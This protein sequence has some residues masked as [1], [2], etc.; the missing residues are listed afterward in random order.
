MNITLFIHRLKREQQWLTT[1]TLVLVCSNSAPPYPETCWRYRCSTILLPSLFLFSCKPNTCPTKTKLF[2]THVAGIVVLLRRLGTRSWIRTFLIIL[3]IMYCEHSFSLEQWQNST[4][5]SCILITWMCSGDIVLCCCSVHAAI[6]Y[7]SKWHKKPSLS[8][9]WT[10]PLHVSHVTFWVILFS[11]N[12][13]YSRYLR[14]RSHSFRHIHLCRIIDWGNERRQ[15]SEYIR[16][17]FHDIPLDDLN[18]SNSN[19]R[20]HS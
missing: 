20:R 6:P 11:S 19:F 9:N 5:Y 4:Q 1:P 13:N 18:I 8:I 17:I 10:T 16:N 3:A 15:T 14:W 2:R 7:Q 12:E